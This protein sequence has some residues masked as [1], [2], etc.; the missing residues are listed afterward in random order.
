M[1]ATAILLICLMAAAGKLAV[2]LGGLVIC[3]AAA[4]AQTVADVRISCACATTLHSVNAYLL[5]ALQDVST[6]PCPNRAKEAVLKALRW[7]LLLRL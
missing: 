1:K 7:V 3:T 2:S 5:L 6:L 4:A